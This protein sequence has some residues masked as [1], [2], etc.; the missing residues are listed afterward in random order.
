MLQT[1]IS[2]D[3]NMNNGIIETRGVMLVFYSVEFFE[4]I[5]QV[6]KIEPEKRNST[7]PK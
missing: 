7:T 2:K 6:N 4:G 1:L 3:N 5:K